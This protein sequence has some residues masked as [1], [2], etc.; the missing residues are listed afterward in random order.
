MAPTSQH[1]VRDMRSTDLAACDM[2]NRYSETEVHRPRGSPLR[3]LHHRLAHVTGWNMGHPETF[4]LEDGM[5]YVCFRCDGCGERKY[6]EP[7]RI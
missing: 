1:K 2:R 4:Y 7:W 3:W 6:V 5:L